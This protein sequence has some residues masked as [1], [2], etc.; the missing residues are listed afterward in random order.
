MADL[1]LQLIA[2]EYTEITEENRNDQG[3]M[4]K[5]QGPNLQFMLVI[6]VWKLV[7]LLLCAL[8]GKTINSQ[9]W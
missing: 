8:C 3:P 6:G 1:I 7:I 5:D 9:P 2:T 4:T